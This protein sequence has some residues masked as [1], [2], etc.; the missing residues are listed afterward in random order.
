VGVLMDVLRKI[1][2][3]TLKILLADISSEEDTPEN[4]S[5]MVKQCIALNRNDLAELISSQWDKVLQKYPAPRRN[6]VAIMKIGGAS[7][8]KDIFGGKE[9]SRW[10]S[11]QE[12]LSPEA[13]M[14][15]KG[16]LTI[17]PIPKDVPSIAIPKKDE[18]AEDWQNAADETKLRISEARKAFKD[19]NQFIIYLE[20]QVVGMQRKIQE[21]GPDGAKCKNRNINF[22]K[23]VQRIPKWEKE[24]AAYVEQINGIK[25]TVKTAEL[26]FL[27]A[28]KSY[29]TAPITTLEFEIK[30]QASLDSVL[31]AI[32]D[33]DDMEQQY[34]LLVKFN[35]TLKK[36][37]QKATGSFEISADFVGK[38]IDIFSSYINQ[39]KIGWVKML[40]WV[41]GLNKSIGGFNKFASLR[42]EVEI[43]K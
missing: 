16:I 28:E 43:D 30:T 3:D 40:K 5:E 18:T 26:D 37:A 32:L 23:Y 34:K 38:L 2:L 20:K 42:Y 15:A 39:L 29:N 31:E 41:S 10:L 12:D 25:N 14:E 9:F 1:I 24:L 6:P 27:S 17:M 19:V 13:K 7:I 33:M 8:R 21:Y 11:E 35:K 22:T 36:Q 4:I